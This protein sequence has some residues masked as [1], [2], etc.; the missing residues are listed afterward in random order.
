LFVFFIIVDGVEFVNP[1]LKLTACAPY[2]LAVANL[3]ASQL[4]GL[5][6][7]LCGGLCGFLGDLVSDLIK[8]HH[9]FALLLFRFLYYSR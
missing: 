7:I 8:V 4:A 9:G 5:L 1:F 3:P 2:T 6:K